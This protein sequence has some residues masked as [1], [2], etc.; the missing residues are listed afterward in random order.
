[1]ADP[2]AG[3]SGWGRE[4]EAAAGEREGGIRVTGMG[5]GAGGLYRKCIWARWAGGSN[6]LTAQ[7]GFAERP[8]TSSRQRFFLIFF[9]IS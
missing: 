3:G 9:K 4:R 8:I 7:V 6:G 5:G 1:M 2:V